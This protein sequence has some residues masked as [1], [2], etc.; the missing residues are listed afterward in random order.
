MIKNADLS[1]CT[2][3]KEIN[4]CDINPAPVFKISHDG[5]IL[6][7]NETAKSL[8]GNNSDSLNIRS[9]FPVMTKEFLQQLSKE[10]VAQFEIEH[11]ARVYLFTFKYSSA[12]IIFYGSDITERA[13]LQAKYDSEVALYKA[14]LNTIPAMMYVK[15]IDLKYLIA[16]KSFCDAVGQSLES[17][18]GKTDYDIF[19]IGKA[20]LIRKDDIESI[21]NNKT[22]QKNEEYFK[23][24]HNTERW[25]STTKVPLHDS[26]GLVS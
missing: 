18:I 10:K 14:M 13:Q 16:N 9:I 11:N 5:T 22:V 20:D 2:S 8:I 7:Y 23:D 19:P 17:L 12:D 6:H 26:Q 24:A 1:N 3:S 25:V 15:D 4:I 21:E